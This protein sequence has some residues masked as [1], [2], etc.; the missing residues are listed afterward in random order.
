MYHRRAYLD[1]H[2]AILKTNGLALG[3]GRRVILTA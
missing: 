1:G 2:D 3:Y